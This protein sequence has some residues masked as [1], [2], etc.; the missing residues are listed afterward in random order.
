MMNRA[1]DNGHRTEI[2]DTSITYLTRRVDPSEVLPSVT[3]HFPKHFRTS[4]FEK[5][6]SDICQIWEIPSDT[7]QYVIQSHGQ[8]KSSQG[9]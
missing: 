4:Q 2:V 7:G 6:Y 8:V 3:V 5:C 9:H 1:Y